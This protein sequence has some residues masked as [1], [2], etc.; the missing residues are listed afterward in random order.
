[1][2][3]NLSL[4]LVYLFVLFSDFL[5]HLPGSLKLGTFRIQDCTKALN[6]QELT[7]SLIDLHSTVRPRL[8]SFKKSG[9][10]NRK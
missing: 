6:S 3:Y 10:T 9:N 2:Y 1:M 7:L 8:V 4:G 5:K